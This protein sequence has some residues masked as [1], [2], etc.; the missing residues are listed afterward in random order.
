[1]KRF[2]LLTILLILFFTAARAQ[3]PQLSVDGKSN[4][5]VKLQNLKIDVAIYGN[6][7]RSTWQ[8][9]FYNSTA[10]VLEGTL[11]FPLKDGVSVSRY[12]LDMNGKMREA[13]P[14]DRGKGT[15]VFESIERRRV[16]PGLLEKVAGNTF[17]TRIYP[18]NPHSTRTIIIGY[19]EE[20]PMTANGSLKFT[21][22]LN[23]QDTVKTF[24]L[25]A[26]VVQS[27][28]APIADDTSGYALKF[29]KHQNTYTSSFEKSNYT[30]GHTLSFYIPKP[31]D[32]AEVMIQAQGNK[33][34]W[35][36]NTAIPANTINKPLPHSIGLLWDASLS[37]AGRDIKKE[38]AL[39]DAYFKKISTVQVSLVAFSNAIIKNKSY[40]ITNGNWAALKTELEQTVYDGATN[41]GKL[42]LTK[43]PA[44]EY[45]LMS[46]GHQTF[47]EGQIKLVRKP[48]YC[49]NSSAAADYSNLKQLALKTGGELIDLIRDDEAKAL[50]A[51]TLQPLRFLGIKAGSTVNDAYPSLPVTVNGAFSVAGITKN[52][53]Q[54]ITLQYGYG[55]NVSIEKQ[56]RLDLQ[57]NAVDNVDVPKLWGQKKISELDINYADNRQEIESLGKR[58][59]IVT[60]N[61]SLIVL[62]TV[63]D[64]I[65]YGIEPPAELRAEYDAVMKQRGTDDDDEPETAGANL[66]AA[67]EMLKALTKWWGTDFTPKP[68]PKP[69]KQ[70]GHPQLVAVRPIGPGTN[71]SNRI[72]RG[73]IRGTITDSGTGLPLVGATVTV[74]RN[75][76]TA[77]TYKAGHYIMDVRPGDIVKVS[78]AGYNAEEMNIGDNEVLNFTLIKTGNNTAQTT[79]TDT[80]IAQTINTPT[81]RATGPGIQG[82]ITSQTDGLPVPGAMVRVKGTSTGTQSDV[83]GDFSLNAPVGSV[84]VVS[85][86]GYTTQEVTVG[87]NRILN[88]QLEGSN[89]A[90]NEVVVVGYSSVRRKDVTGSVT[91]V[92]PLSYDRLDE[93]VGNANKAV[94]TNKD[95]TQQLQGRVAGL[96]VT[97]QRAPGSTSVVLRSQ[98]TI[99][100]GQPIYVVDGVQTSS[101][102]NLNPSEIE[103]INVL[104]DAGATAIYGAAGSNGVVV[105]TTKNGVAA[106]PSAQRADPVADAPTT[107]E[108]ITIAYQ[109]PDA[110]YLKAI[111]IA[112]KTGQYQKYLELRASNAGN[113][114]YYFE[115][116]DYFLKTGNTEEGGRILSNLAEMG[117]DNY[118]LYKMLGYKL[119]QLGDYEGEVF[120]FKKVM[121][122]RPLDPQ[123]F[124]D[125]GLALEDAGHHQQALDVLYKA[126]VSSYTDDAE[127]LYDGIEEIILPEINR[128]IAL[129]K[130][131][132]NIKSI[133][134]TVIKNLPADIRI[135]MDWN[136]NNTDIDLWVTDPNGEK[137]YY[138]HNRTAL[139]GR[140][141][142]DMT[143]GFG[144]EQFLLKKAI[145]GTYKIEINYYGDRQATIAGPTTV[146]AELFTHY[147]T[148][149][150]K[151]EL[152]VLQM[153]KGDKG[154]VYIGDLDF[155]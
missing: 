56:V 2:S 104:K 138:S 31:K 144:P 72:T 52:P 81:A 55:N 40:A 27:A 143:Q 151:K 121:E 28:M 84:L 21:L 96:Q 133:P 43:I 136:M 113:P 54:T 111:R 116:A 71:G 10:Q 8:M 90:L 131:K 34:C 66:P 92:S 29:D 141:S 39:L 20:L 152:I 5:G 146:M 153:K 47:G 49:I 108:G 44:D 4:N 83:I 33:Y 155:K 7:S 62:E 140:I 69:V 60:R 46:D 88:V 70:A 101:I 6:I 77:T 87:S 102:A 15:V 105:V 61:T 114:V 80:A 79:R 32:V 123:S 91:T 37:G 9:T 132:L 22:P 97:T 89:N 36:V 16:D 82:K 67:E 106:K 18:I 59:G 50:S 112:G 25:T 129:N 147:G 124:R 126:M 94:V 150:E 58:F 68:E 115:V 45:L 26:S 125:Y 122:L 38:I 23:L 35:F 139:G 120:A 41:F 103:S 86:I 142:D 3:S 63:A 137:C 130:G 12:A 110:D 11:T 148:P 100:T 119:K 107:G 74:R 78:C 14:V 135:V 30:P 145:K 24:A 65:R 118:E 99:S 85:Y 76:A 128:I 75:G 127:N 93:P 17:R 154:G 42:D 53:N 95:I 73:T 48:V 109:A 51:L 98:S 134:K 19:E 57:A 149:Q 64:Y 117:L 13:V 1:M